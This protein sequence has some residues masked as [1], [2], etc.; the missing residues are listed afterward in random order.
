MQILVH[1]ERQA[2]MID[3]LFDSIEMTWKKVIIFAV[4]SAIFAATMLIIPFTIHTS[5]SAPGTTFEYWILAALVI[6]I[7][8]KKPIEASLKTFV[9]FLISQPL[10]YL[11]QVP[12]SNLG[13]NI[14]M[15]YPRW[16]V[17][18][19]LTIPG[20]FIA[21]YVKKD[22]LLS[23]LILSVATAFLTYQGMY[24]LPYVRNHFPFYSLAFI[25]CFALAFGLIFVLLRD[26]RNRIISLCITFLALI[27]S[28]I[29]F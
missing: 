11:I 22:N 8:C 25:F 26:K 9:F 23:A 6:I 7:N 10:I 19:I 21:W 27:A 17:L 13:W 14:F 16:L 12:F 1:L 2:T 24:Y 29:L 4:I 5:L 20:A 18:T 28:I 15:Y 3:K